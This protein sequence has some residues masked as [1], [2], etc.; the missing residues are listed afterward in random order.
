ML[1]QTLEEMGMDYLTQI[2]KIQPSGPYYLLGWSLGGLVAYSIATCL[3]EQGEQV[4]LLA[5]LDAYPAGQAAV[6]ESP[7]E[8]QILGAAFKLWVMTLGRVPLEFRNSGNC[9]VVMVTL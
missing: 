4:A 7:N 1:P 9:C 6:S 8:Q 2:R 5:L 3:Q